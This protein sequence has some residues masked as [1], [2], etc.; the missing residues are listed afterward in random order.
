MHMKIL[1]SILALLATAIPAPCDS[2]DDCI[3]CVPVSTVHDVQLFNPCGTATKADYCVGEIRK[4]TEHTVL[5]PDATPPQRY[6]LL[7]LGMSSCAATCNK[8]WVGAPW[9]HKAC[10]PEFYSPIRSPR[11]YYAAARDMMTDVI[12]QWCYAISY[13]AA[14]FCR[15]SA[16]PLRYI[17]VDHPCQN[18]PF[19][20]DQDGYKAS[21]AG[22][23]DCVDTIPYI[24]PDAPPICQLYYDANCD[25]VLDLNA[26]PCLSTTPIIFDLGTDGISLT[27]KADGVQFDLDT[28]GSREQISWTSPDTQ[29]SFLC[30]DR[31][32]NGTIDDGTELFGNFT[33]QPDPPEGSEPNGFLALA[34]FDQTGNGGNGDGTID[35]SDSVYKNLLLW[36]D[37]NHNGISEPGELRALA[38]AG[39]SGITL[40]YKLSRKV[41]EYGN[42]FRY[43]AKLKPAKDAADLDRWVWDV[44]LIR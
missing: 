31:N 22:G 21:Y 29:D 28:D 18:C 44:I 38:S 35:G 39:V 7:A 2:F 4:M 11:S 3:S 14:V 24:H 8:D 23:D 25:G 41:D 37:S 32:G 5:W 26:P 12:L 1:I 33:P 13:V 19:D 40:D 43:R 15:G 34:V 27:A 36:E 6:Y 30:L 42:Q 9:T 20:Q 16:G 17:S 10:W